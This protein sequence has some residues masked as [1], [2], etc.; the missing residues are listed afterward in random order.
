MAIRRPT[1]RTITNEVF[2]KIG[3]KFI[4]LIKRDC[5]EQNKSTLYRA[6]KKIE[7]GKLSIPESDNGIYY[8]ELDGSLTAMK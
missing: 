3:S 7:S 2:K 5:F 6:M 4:T 1:A 8:V